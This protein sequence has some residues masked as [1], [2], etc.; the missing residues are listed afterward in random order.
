MWLKYVS[1]II[2]KFNIKMTVWKNIE[3]KVIYVHFVKETVVSNAFEWLS[4]LY[5]ILFSAP[6]RKPGSFNHVTSVVNLFSYYFI[7]LS[8][9]SVTFLFVCFCLNTFAGQLLLFKYSCAYR[10][11]RIMMAWNENLLQIFM[12]IGTISGS[13]HIKRIWLKGFLNFKIC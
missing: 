9:K 1:R 8:Q 2:H 4:D 10:N 13:I 12:R 5:F 6:E 7:Q 3:F 11:N